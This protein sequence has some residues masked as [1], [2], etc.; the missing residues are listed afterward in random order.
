MVYKDKKPVKGAYA[1]KAYVLSSG[2]G[3]ALVRIK[4]DPKEALSLYKQ[5]FQTYP[6][7][8]KEYQSTYYTLL[9]SDRNPDF[10]RVLD[11]ELNTLM[12]SNDEKDLVLAS[13]LL[14]RI[15]KN[16]QADSLTEVV[17]AKYPNVELVKSELEIA[18][19]NEKDPV[20]KKALY[21]EYV[22][23]HP[24]II[25]GNK[26]DMDS[27]QILSDNFHMMQPAFS[28]QREIK[29]NDYFIWQKQLQDESLLF[30]TLNRSAY[31]WAQKGELLDEAATISKQSLDLVMQKIIDSG[32]QPY[33]SP[34][35][36]KERYIS[37]YNMFA[38]TYAFILFKQSKF[39]EALSYE[40]PVYEKSKG[41]DLEV[42]ERY[43]QI[44]IAAGEEQKAKQV[45]ETAIAN[46]KSSDIMDV[47]LKAFYVKAKGSD[48][49][50]AQYLASLENNVAPDV[51]ANL[52]K[53]M[54]NKPAPAFALKDLDGNTVSL[55]S[56]KGKV[57]V[58]DFWATWCGGC[59]DS[60]PAMQLA[61][62]KYKDN[63]NVKFLFID[64]WET[65]K[66]YLDSVKKFITRNHYNLHVLIDE[67]SEDN[68]QAKVV[69]TYKVDAIPTKFILDKNGNIRFRKEGF[70][71]TAESIRDEVSAMIELASGPDLAKS[72]KVNRLK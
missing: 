46:D 53:K 2:M 66:N 19:N 16:T 8:K 70:E 20:K 63:P 34:K 3:N 39:K 43:T 58:I 30:Q 9:T 64:T 52:Y 40:Q 41:N 17:K 54:I 50:Y 69:S 36:L 71:G 47:G 22:K 67:K 57:V 51:K 72:E 14:R 42:N 55:A 31:N 68:R 32:F 24:E 60:F 33:A 4:T 23:K 45:I 59:I 6:Q 25:A 13:G 27:L 48:A 38:D 44:L 18:F 35:M 49:G 12:K 21:I 62:D 28:S 15:E 26:K 11:E 1:S 37:Y 56:L 7:S 5:E 29:Y 61:A 10:T 65:K